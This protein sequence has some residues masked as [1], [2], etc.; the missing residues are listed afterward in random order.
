MR[1]ATGYS[2]PE[3]RSALRGRE[4]LATLRRAAEE[5]GGAATPAAGAAA[6]GRDGSQP[7]LGRRQRRRGGAARHAGRTGTHPQRAHASCAT[8]SSTS[9]Y[10]VSARSQSLPHPERP[11]LASLR[12]VCSRVSAAC[13]LQGCSL[14]Q[15]RARRGAALAGASGSRRPALPAPSTATRSTTGTTAS[16]RSSVRV[17]EGTGARAASLPPLNVLVNVTAAGV[18]AARR[19]RRRRSGTTIYC[20]YP[21]ALSRSCVPCYRHRA[22]LGRRVTWQLDNFLRSLRLFAL[23]L[24]LLCL[25][26]RVLLLSAQPEAHFLNAA[27][28]FRPK[29]LKLEVVATREP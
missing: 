17:H 7:T 12:R 9:A 11:A 6:S 18:T 26:E 25:S 28:T 14:H 22:F 13:G 16:S 2:G 8:T 21:V 4:Q 15:Q 23:R 19:M 3:R 29:I 10:C 1:R 27:D 20:G 24:A 5:R